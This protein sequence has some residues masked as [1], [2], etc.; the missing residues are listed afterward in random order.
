[1]ILVSQIKDQIKLQL[2]NQQHR[3]TSR[4]TKIQPCT[5]S[6]GQQAQLQQPTAVVTA[7][8]TQWRLDSSPASHSPV[9]GSK[10]QAAEG[11]V[12]RWALN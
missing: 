8:G 4:V 3:L 10:L 12:H 2:Y 9:G 5:S 1:M 7:A 6:V 11:R